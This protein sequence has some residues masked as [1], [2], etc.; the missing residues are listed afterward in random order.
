[1]VNTPVGLNNE[2]QA[3]PLGKLTIQVAHSAAHWRQ[4]KTAL[5]REHRLGRDAK[6]RISSVSWG[7]STGTGGRAGLVR[8]ASQIWLPEA[9]RCLSEMLPSID[10]RNETDRQGGTE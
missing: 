3:Q 10:A 2:T 7:G 9:C 1:M 4:A 5:G 8:I 6:P